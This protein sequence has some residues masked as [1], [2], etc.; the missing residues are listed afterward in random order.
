MREF[1]SKTCFAMS[2]GALIILLSCTSEAQS[3]TTVP[4]RRL[5][6][7]IAQVRMGG[8]PKA[9]TDAAEC[10]AQLTHGIDP[11]KVDDKTL[12]DLVSLLDV[13]DDSVRYWVARSLGNLGPRAK[14]AAPRLQAILADVD[15]LPG[16]KTS[17]SGIRFALSQ[18]GVTP[19]PPRCGTAK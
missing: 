4:T 19:P 15:C 17:A 7:A 8:S 6:K 18:I 2:L 13:S 9:R 11:T 16:S 14:M 1:R 3:N 5:G 12:G 10:L